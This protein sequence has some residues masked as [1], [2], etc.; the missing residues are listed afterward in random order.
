MF[1][2]LEPGAGIHINALEVYQDTWGWS[3]TQRLKLAWRLFCVV[4]LKRKEL[5]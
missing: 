3:L 2:E 5:Y 1:F 4:V